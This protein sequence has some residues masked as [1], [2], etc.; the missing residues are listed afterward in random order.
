M[1]SGRFSHEQ[2]RPFVMYH[3]T[4]AAALA[5]LELYDENSA[6]LA[7]EEV[8]IGL[9]RLRQLFEDYEAEEQFEE[10]ELIQRLHEFKSGLKEKY[11]IGRTLTER[12]GDAIES[13]DYELAAE[14]RDQL[15][16]RDDDI[17]LSA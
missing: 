15:R 13:E 3:R 8:N 1:S 14:I 4:Q 12:L 16:E 6:E 17:D 10:D 7:I 5:K 2:Y 11:E 9:Q